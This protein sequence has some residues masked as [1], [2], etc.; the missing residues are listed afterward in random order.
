MLRYVVVAV[1]G[2]AATPAPA[3]EL[4]ALQGG[5]I[6]G[7]SFHGVIFYSSE[8]G[9]YHVVATIADG[10][11][12][13]PVR[14]EATLGENQKLSISTPGKLGEQSDIVEISRAGDRLV[15]GPPPPALRREE[16]TSF[17]WTVRYK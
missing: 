7:G 15:V 1:L 13:L 16:G 2:C 9:G 6:E 11:T 3:G 10:E 5:S 14:F 8:P 4:S 12:G 17:L